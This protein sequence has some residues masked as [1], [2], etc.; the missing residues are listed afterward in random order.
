MPAK[1]FLLLTFFLLTS[2]GLIAQQAKTDSLENLLSAEKTDT[3]K[4]KIMW[5]WAGSINVSDP[6][7]ALQVSQQALF[8]ATK[9]KYTEGQ[10][11]ALGTMAYTFNIMGNYPKAL[12]LN[13]RRLKLE[14]NGKNPRNL[15]MA[16][17]NIGIV[18]RYQEEYNEALKYYYRSDSVIRRH[19]I[20]EI[21]YYSYMN[22]GDVYDRLGKNDSAFSYFNKSL[23]ISNQL[24][25]DDYIGA[26]MTGLGHTYFKQQNAPFSLLYYRTAI[27]YLQKAG[28]D[29]VL[30]EAM[31]GLAKLYREQ[32]FKNDSAMYY[33]ASTLNIAGEGGILPKQLEAADFLTAFYKAS[34]N[35]D[36]AYFYLSKVQQLNDSVNGREKIRQLQMLSSDEKFRQLEI[37]ENKTIAKK[38]RKQ[39]LQLLFIGIFIPGF[40][41]LTLLLSR[42]RI[43][44]RVIKLLGILSLLILFEYLTLLLHPTVAKL[45]N[46][47]PI[48][49]IIIFVCIAA[50]L[51]PAHHRIEHWLIEKLI[52]RS[53]SIKLKNLKLKV[54]GPVQ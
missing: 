14:E 20:E 28:N 27:N 38:E 34:G 36:S 18:Y 45:T 22:L 15:A 42:I 13:L 25:N 40:F 3:G 37:E 9:L 53:G 39:Q 35:T 10:S 8:M 32:L 31:L 5:K 26:S 17:L 21:K 2:I 49:E 29:D 46:Y 43:H 30:C 19:D 4:V 24:K 23:I 48:Y 50:V 54:K 1:S 52:H 41:L 33:A 16:L 7:K 6:E 12:E 11:M 47:T 51:I 44:A